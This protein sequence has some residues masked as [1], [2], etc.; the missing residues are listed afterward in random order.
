MGLDAE[1][2]E[3][4]QSIQLDSTLLPDDKTYMYHLF[5]GTFG[6]LTIT[7]SWVAL[8]TFMFTQGD[9]TEAEDLQYSYQGVWLKLSLEAALPIC[10]E[11][12]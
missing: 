8:K 9:T 1:T 5:A 10:V 2:G 3:V 4:V 7:D 6:A 11:V 12:P